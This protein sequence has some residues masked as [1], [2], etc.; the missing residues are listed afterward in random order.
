M[1][2]PHDTSAAR[3]KILIA[4]DE[5]P[6]ANALKLKFEAKGYE[7]TLVHNGEDALSEVKKDGYSLVLL[8]LMMPGF[9]GFDFLE[10]NQKAGGKVPVIVST[11]LSQEEDI[12]RA[13]D[14]GATDYFV[15]S[16][17]PISEVVEKVENVLQRA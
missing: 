2:E 13:T 17:T 5:R 10:A 6:M 8:D 12:K 16:N 4:E 15:K 14:L 1:T 3:K 9:D 11:N 7:V